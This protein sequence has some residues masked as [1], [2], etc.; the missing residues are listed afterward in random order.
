MEVSVLDSIT[1]KVT[2][3]AKAAA[4]ISGSVVEIT[5]LNMSINAEEE[6]IRKLYTEIGKQLYEDYTDGK[7]VSEE[8]LRKCVKID[9]IFEN[10]ADMKDKILELR[11]VK[12]CPN[13][14]TIL[15]IEMEYCH[16]CGKKQEDIPEAE[17]ENKDDKDSSKDVQD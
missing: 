1:R 2:D 11:N 17:E 12:A 6:K 5:K 9:E 8:L 14:G 15:D 13:C 3:T 7:A 16:K 4:K 10:I